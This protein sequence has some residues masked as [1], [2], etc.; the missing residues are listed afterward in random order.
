MRVP[1]HILIAP[2][3][4]CNPLWADYDD[5]QPPDN[6]PWNDLPISP[7]LGAAI[8]AWDLKLQNIYDFNDPASAAFR[9]EEDER[10][11]DE[12]GRVLWRRLQDELRGW[13]TVSYF[14]RLEEREVE[15]QAEAA[16]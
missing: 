4:A 11:F 5:G 12:E 1:N 9:S 2:E 10:A 15:P 14:S 7:E 3:V 6:V 16:E 13:T 8:D